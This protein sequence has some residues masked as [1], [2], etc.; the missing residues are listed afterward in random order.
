MMMLGAQRRLYDLVQIHP[1]NRQHTIRP[2]P[3]PLCAK[4]SL[5]L[6]VGS[7]YLRCANLLLSR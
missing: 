6:Y 4:V 1:A 5:S 7:K 3:T 2:V